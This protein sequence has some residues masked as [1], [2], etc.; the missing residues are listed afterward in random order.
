VKTIVR[1]CKMGLASAVV[2][3]FRNACGELFVVMDADLQHPP[4]KVRDMIDMALKGY[5]IVIGSRYIP[6]GSVKEFP[7]LDILFLVEL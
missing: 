2:G 3:G 5:N 6:N 1:P 4:E 7:F